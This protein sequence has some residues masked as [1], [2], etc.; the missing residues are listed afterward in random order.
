MKPDG[1]GGCAPDNITL[2]GDIWNIGLALIDIMVRVAGIAVVFFI[3]YAGI[4]YIT[5]QGNAEKAV[6][7][8]KRI[9][10]SLVGLAIIIT[11]SVAVAFIGNTIGK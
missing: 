9:I 1:V 2:P 10:N 5:S 11:A 6:A 4:N 8:R 7:A 3:I